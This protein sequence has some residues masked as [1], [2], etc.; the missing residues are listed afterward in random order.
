MSGYTPYYGGGWQS[1]ESG[2]TPITPAALNNME[3]GI[4]AALTAVDVVNNLTSTATDKPLS[5][6]QGKMLNTKIDN[7]K[8][9]D[10]VAANGSV[11]I[12]V[13][14]DAMYI[15]IASRGLYIGML[16]YDTLIDI[17]GSK[18]VTITKNGIDSI[19]VSNTAGL[20][21]NIVII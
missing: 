9:A 17:A 3:N 6:A 5:A 19:T 13:N 10:N 1:G 20:S 7:A 12:T 14:P 2:G 21:N 4:G 16:A 18:T 11:T 8:Y 15:V